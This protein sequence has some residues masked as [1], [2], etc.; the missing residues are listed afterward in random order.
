VSAQLLG[1]SWEHSQTNDIQ[2]TETTAPGFGFT[3]AAC[4]PTQPCPW[5]RGSTEQESR[6]PMPAAPQRQ[7]T[8]MTHFWCLYTIQHN[9]KSSQTCWRV[10]PWLRRLPRQIHL[11]PHTGTPATPGARCLPGSATLSH[12]GR[13]LKTSRV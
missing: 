4:K 1:S 7:F 11:G 12:R 2:T 3:V 10:L 5:T 13:C 6:V 8:I 9:R